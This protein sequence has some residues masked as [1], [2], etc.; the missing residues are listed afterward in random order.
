MKNYT[1]TV[2][3]DRTVTEIEGLLIRAGARSISKEYSNGEIAALTFVVLCPESNAPLGVRLPADVDAVFGVLKKARS[4]RARLHRGW[5]A[6]MREQAKRTAWR[7]MFDW[8][9]VQLSL[10]EMRQAEMMQVFLPYIWSG[11][12]TFYQQLRENKFAALTYQGASD[13]AGEG[14]GE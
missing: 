7:L 3:A 2:P 1:S 6:K 4:P 10:I 14:P 11:R 8:V 5:E 9:A 13:Q 12:G